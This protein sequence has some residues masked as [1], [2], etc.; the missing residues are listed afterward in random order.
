LQNKIRISQKLWITLTIILIFCPKYF[1]Q[2][3]FL[4]KLFSNVVDFVSGTIPYQP[5]NPGLA[6]PAFEYFSRQS[7]K[8]KISSHKRAVNQS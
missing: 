5:V 3:Y 1:G 8:L 6:N 7:F 2:K 4:P